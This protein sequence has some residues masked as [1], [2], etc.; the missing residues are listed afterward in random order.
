MSIYEK[1]FFPRFCND[2]PPFAFIKGVSDAISAEEERML[3]RLAELEKK[4]ESIIGRIMGESQEDADERR[5]IA[6]K[7]YK[8]I[9]RYQESVYAEENALERRNFFLDKTGMLYAECICFACGYAIYLDDDGE[10]S[11]GEITESSKAGN[12]RGVD[13]RLCPLSALS[14]EDQAVITC[15]VEELPFVWCKKS[16]VER[17]FG[18]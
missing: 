3:A 1:E 16:R 11:V 2:I 6:A 14:P 5:N 15:V 17:S 7:H 8:L 9:S 12:V 18:L 10:L 4:R 13:T